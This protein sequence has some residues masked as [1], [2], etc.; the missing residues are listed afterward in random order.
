MN[1]CLFVA[2][3]VLMQPFQFLSNESEAYRINSL[4]N[5]VIH[6]ILSFLDAQLVVQ[7]SILSKQWKCIL[8]SIPFPPLRGDYTF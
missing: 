8:K 2:N 4:S 1:L 6:R 5:E 7:T 3:K